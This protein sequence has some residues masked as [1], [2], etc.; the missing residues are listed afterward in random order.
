LEHFTWSLNNITFPEV[1][2]IWADFGISWEVLKMM[3]HPQN[4]QEHP[5]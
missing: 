3:N 5:Q 1:K 4:A 2:N